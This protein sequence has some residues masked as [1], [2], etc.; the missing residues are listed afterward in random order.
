MGQDLPLLPTS[1]VGSYSPPSWLVSASEAIARDEFGERDIEETLRDAVRIAVLDQVEAGVDII[2][3][4]EMRRQ[5]FNLGFYDHMRGL[6][7]LPLQRKKGPEGH[8][9]RGRWDVLEPVSAPH[10]LGIVHEFTYL[11][12]ISSAALKA[13]CPGPFT[14][15][16]RLTT[17][18]VYA[19]RLAATEALVPIVNAE[20]KALVA[21]GAEFIQLDEPSYAVYPDRPRL[22]IDFFNRTVD[23]VNAKIG[24]HMCFGNYRGRP[25]GR[26]GYRPLFPHIFDVHAHQFVL[27]FANREL[28]EL[29]LWQTFPNDRELGAGLIDVKNYYIETADDVAERV[30]ATLRHV[31]PEKLTVLPDC[32]FSQTARWAAVRKLQ[33]MVAGTKIVRAELAGRT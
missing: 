10:G 4:G 22:F 16:G 32:G 12:S 23:G 18:A 29:E 21:A 28:A 30:R 20:C 31:K 33:S 8:D 5:D 25:V 7:Q 6:R 3:D 14:L 26:R 27:E 19:D 9:Q 1:V 13:T 2:T 11:K 17:G 15:A 24:I